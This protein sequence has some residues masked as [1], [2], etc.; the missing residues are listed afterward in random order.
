[1]N[2]ISAQ[3][4]LIHWNLLLFLGA[5]VGK[6]FGTAAWKIPTLSCASILQNLCS[7]KQVRKQLIPEILVRARGESCVFLCI[8]YPGSH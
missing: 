4:W 3:D 2:V 5:M 6:L 8:S 7:P 1:M